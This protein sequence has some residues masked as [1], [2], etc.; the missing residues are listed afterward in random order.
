MSIPLPV[1]CWWRFLKSAQKS[2][3][4]RLISY[5][6]RRRDFGE[7][8]TMSHSCAMFRSHDWPMTLKTM[9]FFSKPMS[10]ARAISMSMRSRLVSPLGLAGGKEAVLRLEVNMVKK[11]VSGTDYI[12]IC[13]SDAPI[14]KNQAFSLFRSESVFVI[15]DN[16][17]MDLR[18][19][20]EICFYL[21][22]AI[23]S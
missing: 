18:M 13:K 17:G 16:I 19:F 5:S 7:T 6:Q 11:Y 14:H 22:S 20:V 1:S 9:M 2:C 3:Q 12:L 4:V 21:L 15:Q 23:P 10:L 8:T